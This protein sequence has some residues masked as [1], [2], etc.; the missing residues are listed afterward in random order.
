MS[1]PGL[2]FP[3]WLVAAWKGPNRAGHA[4]QPTQPTNQPDMNGEKGVRQG[5]KNNVFGKMT[6]SFGSDPTIW[7][8]NV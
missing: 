8:K 5:A 6:V 2:F 7:E 4:I 1:L 3:F